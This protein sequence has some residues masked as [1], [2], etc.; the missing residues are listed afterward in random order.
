MCVGNLPWYFSYKIA[1]PTSW[2]WTD[3]LQYTS[4]W[5][6]TNYKL[7]WLQL[8]TWYHL[9]WTYSTTTGAACWIN[10][11]KYVLSSSTS[12]YTWYGTWFYT[13]F[14]S[15]GWS[16]KAIVTLSE[17]IAETTV[18]TDQQISD[19]FNATKATYWVS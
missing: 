11:T 13:E 10:W 3:R 12:P 14:L 19:Y 9:V 17:A 5:P 2:G 4:S 18:R 1:E 16:T 6:T 8:N 7:A 15:N